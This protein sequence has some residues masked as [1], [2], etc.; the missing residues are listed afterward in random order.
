[1]GLLLE[2]LKGELFL[3][4]V[5]HQSPLLKRLMGLIGEHCPN[6]RESSGT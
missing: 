3:A 2:P 1:M 4:H 5:S 6:N